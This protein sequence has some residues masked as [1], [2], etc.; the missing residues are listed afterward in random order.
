[1]LPNIS[2]FK[3]GQVIALLNPQGRTLWR[4]EKQTLWEFDDYCCNK[5]K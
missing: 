2:S 1:M 3:N 4:R 5:S